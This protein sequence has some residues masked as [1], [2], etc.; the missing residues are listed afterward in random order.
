MADRFL[1]AIPADFSLREA[2]PVAAGLR[3]L[4]VSQLD[5]MLSELSGSRSESFELAVH[6]TR[7]AA[8]RIRALLRLVRSEIGERAYKAENQLLRDASRVVSVVRDDRVLVT[9]VANVRGRYRDLLAP[10]TFARLEEE[11]DQRANN[12][13]DQLLDSGALNRLIPRLAAA[14]SRY[15]AWP[16][17]DDEIARAYGYKPIRNRFSSISPG[18]QA[19]YRRGRVEMVKGLSTRRSDDLHT[20]R[21]RVKYLRHQLELL[22][23]IYPEALGAMAFSLNRLGEIMGEEHD[24]AELVAML[25]TDSYLCPDPVERSMLVALAHDRR[26]QLVDASAALGNRLYAESPGRFIDRVGVYWGAG[27]PAL[28]D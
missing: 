15:Q 6:Q 12:R 9:T 11:L 19:T 23:P 22:S 7:K 20:W 4:S 14:R 18:L 2:E 16:V 1:P 8:K 17:D 10:H 25:E 21:K 13:R 28:P 3:R 24:L 26:R 5:L 27:S